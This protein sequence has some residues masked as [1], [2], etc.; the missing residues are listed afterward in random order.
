MIISIRIRN[1]TLIHECA[2]CMSLSS[3][4]FG[5]ELNIYRITN[6]KIQI[7]KNIRRVTE[8]H[9]DSRMRVT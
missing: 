8:Q 4:V 2:L 1:N 3:V 5:H 9:I 6:R 7:E